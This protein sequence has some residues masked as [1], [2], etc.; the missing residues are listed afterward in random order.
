MAKLETA[1]FLEGIK[2]KIDSDSNIV[3]RM[4]NGKP[5]IYVMKNRRQDVDNEVLEGNRKKFGEVNAKVCAD[6]RDEE[7]KAYWEK[8]AKESN[9][10]YKT[11]RGAAWA[12]YKKG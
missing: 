12:H 10:E 6:L 5:H 9:G 11:A 7:K 3:Y 4:R 1:S 8:V 2:G